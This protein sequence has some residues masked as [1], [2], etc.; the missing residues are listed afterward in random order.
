M[1][2]TYRSLTAALALGEFTVNAL[3]AEADVKATTVRTVLSRHGRFFSVATVASGRPGGQPRVRT[4]REENRSALEDLIKEFDVRYVDGQDSGL[5]LTEAGQLTSRSGLRLRA[6][7]SNPELATSDDLNSYHLQPSI[8]LLPKLVQRLLLATPELIGLSVAVGEGIQ[9]T[10]YD[11]RVEMRAVALFAPEGRSVWEFGA[12]E[13]P[14]DKANRDLATRTATHLDVIPGE[15]VFVFATSRR[16]ANKVDWITRAKARSPWKDIVVIDADDLYSWVLTHPAVHIWLSEEMGLHPSEVV[17]LQAWFTQWRGQ[18]HTEIPM[19]VLTAGRQAQAERLRRDAARA[20]QLVSVYANSRQ[21]AL[22]FIAEALLAQRDEDAEGDVVGAR[23]ASALVVK[24]ASEWSR[25]VQ[26]IRDGVLIPDFSQADVSAATARGLTVILPMGLGSD[27]RRADI[28][29]PRINL[30][31]AA[32]RLSDGGLSRYDA[33]RI[34]RAID[35]S[36]T[37]FRRADSANPAAER[38]AWADSSSEVIAPLIL[39]GSWDSDSETDHQVVAAVTG[40]SYAEVEH[41]L[42]ALA[43]HED[44]PLYRSGDTWQLSSPSDAFVLVEAAMTAGVLDAWT[45]A[46]IDVLGEVDPT[47]DVSPEEE[48]VAATRGIRLSHS[49]AL[50]AGMTRGAVLLGTFGRAFQSAHADRLVRDLLGAAADAA[51]WMSLSDVL[52][53]LAEASPDEF[54]NAVEDAVAGTAP[55]LLAMFNDAGPAPIWG[56]R[57]R[58]TG[59]LWALEL[60]CHAPDQASRACLVLAR[61]CAIDPGGRLG[62][63]PADSLRRA[64]LPWHPQVAVNAD[65]RLQIVATILGRDAEIGWKLLLGLLPGLFDS[66]HPLFSPTIRPWD[67]AVQ[68]PMAER[69]A[70]WKSL[71][72]LAISEAIRQPAR[73]LQLLE[74]MQTFHPDDRRQ[75]LDVLRS[76]DQAA[77]DPGV[78]LGAWRTVSDLVAK[79]RQFP[80]AQ[81]VLPDLEL[82]ALDALADSWAPDDPVERWAH[83]FV[84]HPSIAYRRMGNHEEYDEEVRRLR[85]QALEETLS[86]GV[87]DGLIRLSHASSEPFAVGWSVGQDRGDQVAEAMLSWF[88]RT[89]ALG[90]AAHG[91]LTYLAYDREPSWLIGFLKKVALLDDAA[92][93]SVYSQI[94]HRDEV[95]DLIRDETPEVRARFWQNGTLLWIGSERVEEIVTGLLEYGRPQVALSYLAHKA[96]G[97]TLEPELVQRVLLEAATVTGSEAHHVG[98]F[99]YEVGVLLDLLEQ[100]VIDLSI[101]A[102]LELIYFEVL[103]YSRPPRALFKILEQEPGRFVELVCIVYRAEDDKGVPNEPDAHAQARWRVS[104]GAL[105]LWRRPPGTR[106]DGSIDAEVLVAWVRTARQLLAEADRADGGDECIGQLLSGSPDGSDGIWPAEPVRQ[107]LEEITGSHLRAGFEIGR[108]NARG[109]TMRGAFDGGRQERALSEQY[110]SWSRVVA[111]RWPNTARILRDLARNY[112]EWAGREDT[113]DEQWRD[114]G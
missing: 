79:H 14:Q 110:D 104:Y 88:G 83:L 69:Y 89:D 45:K 36:L 13:D 81:W 111:A 114:M 18:T 112:Q 26:S 87:L 39:L 72:D 4:V 15:T 85:H 106:D 96:H 43:A 78:R 73:L 12:G 97:S 42:Q 25:L 54:L 101:I 17:T 44:P 29:L 66:T 40:R 16:F 94:P 28:H 99:D 71:T 9:V 22:A 98:S 1:D 63:R 102:K 57:S 108:F 32:N 6:P 30:L 31:D 91:W 65:E 62:N 64:L 52:P 49:A 21:E 59:L 10:G 86:D 95:L 41:L 61:L 47:L 109:V 38:P 70:G 113:R 7:S 53:A 107:L 84:G 74:A 77:W 92:R 5:E 19:G 20:G 51:R 2:A 103:E 90:T 76:A 68:A 67:T 27:Y 82:D 75:L 93:L 56:D 58:H 24:T 50:R 46:A 35:R 33:D 34:A 11:A 105:R 23:L 100:T 80:D 55:L 3:A 48:L 37:S 60:L 8:D